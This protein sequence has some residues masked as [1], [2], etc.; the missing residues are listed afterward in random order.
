VWFSDFDDITTPST[1]NAD[2]ILPYSADVQLC[3]NS[4]V[5]PYDDSGAKG[6]TSDVISYP[7]TP[8][9]E[10][11][12][13]GHDEEKQT[14]NEDTEREPSTKDAENK[15]QANLSSKQ[16]ND[17]VVELNDPKKPESCLDGG[18]NPL[19]VASDHT[20]VLSGGESRV[21][22]VEN[23]DRD[24]KEASDLEEGEITDSDSD[25]G[26]ETESALRKET[27][28]DDGP[29]T[30]SERRQVNISGN[31]RSQEENS[32]R[33]HCDHEPLV[34]ERRPRR[35]SCHGSGGHHHR[36]QRP[37]HH[38]PLSERRNRHSP[39]SI[40]KRTELHVSDPDGRMHSHGDRHT[41]CHRSSRHL[42]SN[43][44]LPERIY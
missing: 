32:K 22:N 26:D 29:G 10:L 41:Q 36:H 13:Q 1:P 44:N 2:D 5:L 30:R 24:K 7:P 17:K 4:A 25:S 8:T 16:T 11:H 18:D 31:H 27:R 40:K 6:N 43:C 3:E 14:T 21:E 9:N 35:S 23:E 28:G 12:V 19:H 15:P 39:P 38:P 37:S 34:D 42:R 20:T 33:S